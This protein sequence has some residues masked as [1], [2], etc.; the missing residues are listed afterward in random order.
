MIS[1]STK[2]KSCQGGEWLIRESQREETYIPEEFQ[3]E[4]RMV[5]EMCSA[6]LDTEVLAIHERI[7]QLEPG[8]MSSL[9]QKAGEQG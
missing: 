5:K 6:F 4:H 7:D 8:L 1:E 9:V 3:E 2:V